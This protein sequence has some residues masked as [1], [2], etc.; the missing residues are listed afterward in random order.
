MKRV[1]VI[2]TFVHLWEAFSLCNVVEA[3]VRMLLKN[4]YDTTFVGCEGFQPRG[5]YANPLLR[6]WRMPAFHLQSDKE[7]VERPAEYRLAVDRIAGALRPLMA[8]ID[9]AITH[10]LAYLQHHLAYNQACRELA[11]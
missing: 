8:R 5:I 7:A 2:T 9:L 11:R 6:Q 1:A 4:G 10:D 3:H